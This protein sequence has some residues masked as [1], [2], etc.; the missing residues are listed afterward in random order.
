MHRLDKHEGVC[1]S[2]CSR[3]CRL[4]RWLPP[5]P[6]P[7]LSQPL[8]TFSVRHLLLSRP[9]RGTRSPS[10][11]NPPPHVTSPPRAHPTRPDI[12]ACSTVG[13]E[14]GR[15]YNRERRRRGGLLVAN[16]DCEAVA[17]CAALCVCFCVWTSSSLS[18]CTSVSV[19]LCP[20][21]YMQASGEQR[22]G[23]RHHRQ[24]NPNPPPH[25]SPYSADALV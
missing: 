16:K 19:G 6:R 24:P 7:R 12:G 13:R 15:W 2:C 21:I 25:L 8:P 23:G 1:V 9:R 10:T 18:V 14:G 17:R 20:S 4:C 5:R 22:G 11:T 3:A